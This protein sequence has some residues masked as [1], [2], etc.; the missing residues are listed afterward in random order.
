MNE[1]WR[2]IPSLSG[3]YEASDLGRIRSTERMVNG[4]SARG[5]KPVKMR[6]KSNILSQNVRGCGY[7]YV[8]V[9]VDG[10]QAK[11]QVHKLVL[12]AFVGMRPEGMQACHGDGNQQNNR[13]D[14]LRWDTPSN[15]QSDRLIHGTDLRGENVKTSKLRPEHA[16]AIKGGMKEKDA[17]TAFGISRTQFYRIKRGEAWAHISAR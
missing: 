16:A 14:N 8:C 2:S 4:Y 3:Y 6:R 1:T 10:K 7:L 5:G 15:N 11:E 9:C 12:M 17:L 13:I